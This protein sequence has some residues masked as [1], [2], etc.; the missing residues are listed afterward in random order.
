MID[1][2]EFLNISE[3][4]YTVINATTISLQPTKVGIER[5]G[6]SNAALLDAECVLIYI[7]DDLAEKNTFFAD[8]LL[9]S[10]QQRIEERRNQ[11]SWL[12]KIFK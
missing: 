9:Q 2:K 5:L 12:T 10:V 3:E 11:F 7:L 1:L 8:K 4:E 6:I